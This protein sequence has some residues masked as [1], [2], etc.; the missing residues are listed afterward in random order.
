MEV[1]LRR[2][3]DGKILNHINKLTIGTERTDRRVL[4]KDLRVLFLII[5]EPSGHSAFLSVALAQ[6]TLQTPVGRRRPAQGAIAQVDSR[7]AKEVLVDKQRYPL[8][9]SIE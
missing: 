4:E 9:L 5:I 6:H 2:R 3:G 7:N 8:A 1:R